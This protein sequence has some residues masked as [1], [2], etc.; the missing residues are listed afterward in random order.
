MTPKEPSKNDNLLFLVP[1]SENLQSAEGNRPEPPNVPSAR[2][3]IAKEQRDAIARCFF[4]GDAPDSVRVLSVRCHLK[5]ADIEGILR[6]HYAALVAKY[7]L[8]SGIVSREGFRT[9]KAA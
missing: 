7:N 6:E 2:R 9:R 4:R 1:S 3:W 5:H 8:I